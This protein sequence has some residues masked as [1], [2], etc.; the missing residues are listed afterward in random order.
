MKA[1]VSISCCCILSMVPHVFSASRQQSAGVIKVDARLVEVYATIYDHKGRYVDGLSLDSFQILE[2]GKP[3]KITNFE[4]TTESLSCAILLDTT[5]SMAEALPR[6]KNSIVKLLDALSPQDS[7]AIYT[8]DQRLV[9]RQEFTTDK[10]AAKRAV[11]RTRAE[12]STA[13]FDALSEVAQDVSTRSGKKALV[14][15]T[16]GDDN[17][18]ALNASA[19]VARAKKAGVP[20]YAIAEGE[21]THSQKLKKLLDDLSE[22]TGGAAYQVK[23]PDDIEP[24]FREISQGLQHLYMIAYQPP[25]GPAGKW[26]KVSLMVK[27]LKDCRIRAKEGYFPN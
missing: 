16:D 6:V 2:D 21:A 3:Q 9:V 10:S 18:S 20:L 27:G 14:V 5:G 22:A 19:A 26:R 8:F 7:V 17:A 24:V 4:A 25:L 13:L 11:L 23:N 12:G 15:F 1:I